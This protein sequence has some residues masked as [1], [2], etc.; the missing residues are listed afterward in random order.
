[1]V[2]HIVDQD[3]F[4]STAATLQTRRNE[5]RAAWDI[6]PDAVTFLFAGKFI[7]EKQP[8]DFIR[9]ISLAATRD[10]EVHGLM[11]GDGPLRE[12]SEALAQVLCA[13]MTFTGFLNQS[14]MVKA[15][16]AADAL[17]LPSRN[18]TWGVVVNEAMLCGR[19]CFVSDRAGCG[20]DLIVSG[21]TGELF[22]FGEVNA[23][24]A[25]INKYVLRPE[26]LSRMGAA[27]KSYVVTQTRK[28][29]VD[30]LLNALAFTQLQRNQ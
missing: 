7:D 23:L 18:E 6:D 11:V 4:S 28:P 20:P 17:I 15:Y 24:A 8:L 16:V 13:P 3:F 26:E 10:L 2:P 9:A 21:K 12:K 30:G 19:P 5:L 1:M 14:E 29:S 22:P 27:A 25:L